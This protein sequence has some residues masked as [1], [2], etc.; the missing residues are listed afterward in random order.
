MPT[1]VEQL[2]AKKT[3]KSR[4][5]QW[6]LALSYEIKKNA[7]KVIQEN[8]LKRVQSGALSGKNSVV[9]SVVTLKNRSLENIDPW[10]DA[11][12]TPEL[13]KAILEEC[14][15]NPWYFFKV[16]LKPPQIQLLYKWT[17][18]RT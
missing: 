4:E 13:K 14:R 16:A 11:S 8:L 15:V 18:R 17:P 2:I 3:T 9:P 1:F 12:L 6:W 5:V 10:D 7:D